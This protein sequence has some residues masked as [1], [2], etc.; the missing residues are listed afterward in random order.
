M[1]AE[2][3]SSKIMIDEATGKRIFQLRGFEASWGFVQAVGVGDWIFVSGTVSIDDQGVP[4]APGDM[5]AQVKNAYEDVAASLA[6]HGATMSNIVREA[7]FTTDLPRFIAE[8]APARL[9]AYRGHSLPASA[10]WLEV[11]RLAQPE[12]LFEVEV[13]A[14]LNVASDSNFLQ[15][16]S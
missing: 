12:F 11:P 7:L 16:P 14:R 8:G 13:I 15:T 10:P 3:N 5:A 1:T 6:A 2:A 9:E 4:R